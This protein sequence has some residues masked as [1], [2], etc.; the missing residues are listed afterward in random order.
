MYLLCFL[1]L[2]ASLLA[3]TDWK[4]EAASIRPTAAQSNSVSIN[5]SAG[6]FRTSNTSLFMLIAHAYDARSFQVLGASGWMQD[7][8]FDITARMEETD[9]AATVSQKERSARLRASV[10]NLLA[11]RFQLKIHEETRELPVYALVL[12]KAGQHKLKAAAPRG[13]T[14]TNQNN[15]TGR[16]RGEGITA[17][18]LAM[19]LS[20][21]VG[22]TVID[23]T[24]L[25][26]QTFDLELNWSDAASGEG[27]SVFTAVKEQLGLRLESK[28][29]PVPVDV[30]D[31]ASKPSEN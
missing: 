7:A 8:R 6:G 25:A 3:Q 12:D 18:S 15:G 29:G 11:E 30:I 20:G 16:M 31:S 17:E 9:D 13:S 23:E 28:K 24:G 19:S 4:F 14:N 1:A 27:P 2:A 5:T 22:R 26:S 21:L 10:R